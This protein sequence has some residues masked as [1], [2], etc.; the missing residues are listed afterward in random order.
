MAVTRRDFIRFSALGLAGGVLASGDFFKPLMAMGPEGQKDIRH[1]PTVCFMCFWQCGV[2]ARVENGRVVKL[3]GNPYHPLSRGKLCARGNAGMGLLYDEDRLKVPLI[4]TGPR[5]ENRYKKVSWDEALGFVSDKM[6]RIKKD[7]GPEAMA[8]FMHG[9]GGAFFMNLLQAYGSMNIAAPSYSMCIGARNEAFHMTFGDN[10]G[11]AERVDM[12]NSRVIV[13]FGT[14]LGENMHNSLN[15]D[16]AEAISRG[17]EL[18]VVDPRFSTAAGKAK[19]WLPIKPGTD[20]ALLL[21]WINIIIEEGWYDRKYVEKYTRGFDKLR[22]AVRKY[23]PEWASRITD[24]PREKIIETAREIG[25]YAPH[26]CIHPGRHSTWHG[27]DAQRER[28]RAILIAI[29]GGWGR[30]GGHYLKPK[31]PSY[32]KKKPFKLPPFPEPEKDPVQFG[33]YPFAGGEG[34]VPEVRRATIEET[35]YP[36][37]GWIVIGTNLMKSVPNQKETLEAIKKLDLLVAVDVMPFDTVKLADVILPE[38]S[39][40][41]RYDPL[42]K[43]TQ[44][45]LG[46]A[47][48]QPVVKPMYESK[49]AW[50]IAKGIAEK[51]GLG[52][53]FPYQD[54]EEYIVKQAGLWGIDFEELKT[55]GYITLEGTAAPYITPENPPHFGTESGKIEL[56]SEELEMYG[57]DPVPEYIPVDEPPEGY[58]RLLYG[59]SPVHTFSRTTNN[60]WLW[61]L[62]RENEVWINTAIAARLGLKTGDQVVLENQDGVRSNPIKV[63]ATSRIRPDAVYMVHGF[64]VKSRDL[65]R[66]YLRGA[67][68]QRLITRYSMDPI[69]GTAG[70]RVNFVKI[71]KEA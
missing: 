40:L 63:K 32:L 13:F 42:I 56:Y 53:Y 48:R 47:L 45:S 29:T 20:M 5:G 15:Q 27:N 46:I 50:W 38:A 22:K 55:R 14:H 68:D 25:R 26:V 33:D 44:K 34:V 54:Y 6:E 65:K 69:T 3:D 64:G 4:R 31:T 57:F 61:E 19:H 60:R 8:L 18:I 41:E 30:K 12:V 10:P 71:I 23:T 67:D 70:M 62:K 51:L 58:L 37:K 66:A 17:A 1:V 24:L 21:A 49:P 16:Y 11:G 59:R 43:V 39:Y 52:A 35:P 28:A 36:V 9:P 7:Y 2:I